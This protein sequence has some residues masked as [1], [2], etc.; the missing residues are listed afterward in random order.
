M[1]RTTRG[2]I[3]A[4]KNSQ[5]SHGGTGVEGLQLA[6]REVLSEGIA[7]VAGAARFSI[8]AAT[9]MLDGKLT[10]QEATVLNTTAGRIL[11]AAELYLKHARGSNKDLLIPNLQQK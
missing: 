10:P 9:D 8:A 4:G 3:E 1:E 6:S 11:K 2:V 5:V 7:S